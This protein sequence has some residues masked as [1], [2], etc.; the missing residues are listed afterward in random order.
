MLD[1]IR[2]FCST[3]QEITTPRGSFS[4]EKSIMLDD[5]EG[6]VREAIFQLIQFY[7]L[8]NATV[9][10]I[11]AVLSFIISCGSSLNKSEQKAAVEALVKL[12]GL[13]RK[14]GSEN[15][16]RILFEAERGELL[17]VS[18][19]K[20]SHCGAFQKETLALF[21]GLLKSPHVSDAYRG[22]I[23]LHHNNHSVM[24]GLFI[25]LRPCEPL[26]HKKLIELMFKCDFSLEDKFNLGQ[27]LVNH[28]A[29]AEERLQQSTALMD[30]L[31]KAPEA[32]RL[33]SQ[34]RGWQ[35][36]LVQSLAV[37]IE[38]TSSTELLD[39]LSLKSL[40][41]IFQLSWKGTGHIQ[42]HKTRWIERLGVWTLLN[43]SLPLNQSII[44]CQSLLDMWLQAALS[45]DRVHDTYTISRDG[46]ILTH[47]FYHYFMVENR[48]DQLKDSTLES[49]MKLLDILMIWESSGLGGDGWPELQRLALSVLLQ[50]LSSKCDSILALCTARLHQII[51]YRKSLPV[52]EEACFILDHFNQTLDNC[53]INPT[54]CSFIFPVLRDI[55][56][57]IPT[58][59]RLAQMPRTKGNAKF[60]AEF[61]DYQ[62][63]EE[64]KAFITSMVKPSS[65]K[66]EIQIRDS[67]STIDI[68]AMLSEAKE[69]AKV[70]GHARDKKNGEAKL[71]FEELL[72][73]P[74]SSFLSSELNRYNKAKRQ[75]TNQQSG[76]L[77]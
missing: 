72:E 37:D 75:L 35:D 71:A 70:A 5:E 33:A 69:A 11:D 39:E 42:K 20:L 17:W 45:S 57:Q 18:M 62:K 25:K 14:T 28:H 64:W 68:L 74:Y 67:N 1:V 21:L 52:I 34:I 65:K 55:L 29:R 10:E 38:D 30:W 60:Q 26:V 23:R 4:S 48:I 46:E 12:N 6:Q 8:K 47:L 24:G 49:L 40:E 16:V 19:L 43:D 3:N 2:T 13:L 54:A 63:T 66:F 51:S 61:T 73:T 59:S 31:L 22:R 44:Q 27:L 76:S 9:E 53:E 15:L 50:S 56:E 32:V 36:T 77:R 7:M 41:V 58:S